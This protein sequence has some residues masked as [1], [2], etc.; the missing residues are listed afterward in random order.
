MSMQTGAAPLE[1]VWIVIEKLTINIPCNP[2]SAYAQRTEHPAPQIL[3]YCCFVHNREEV[4][5]NQ[6]LNSW[7]M[8]N[9]HVVQVYYGILFSCK[10]KSDTLQLNR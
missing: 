10:K 3:A 8:V 5:T 7:L 2:A 1:S 6:M 4:K 9:E